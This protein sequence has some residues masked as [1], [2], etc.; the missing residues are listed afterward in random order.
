MKN[1]K[2]CKTLFQPNHFNHKE[3]DGCKV[4]GKT[5]CSNC[6]TFTFC[7]GRKQ[8]WEHDKNKHDHTV[9]NG[10]EIMIIWEYDFNKDKQGTIDKC[11]KFLTQ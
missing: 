4:S 5:A 7:N 8:I 11:I 1:C 6:K 3:C 2:H 10:K 9:N